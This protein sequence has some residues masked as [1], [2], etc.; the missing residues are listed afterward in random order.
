MDSDS[1]IDTSRLINS[2]SIKKN[3]GYSDKISFRYTKMRFI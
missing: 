1:K 3:K 2:D